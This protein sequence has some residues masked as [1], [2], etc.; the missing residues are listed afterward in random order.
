MQDEGNLKILRDWNG[1]WTALNNLTYVR[2]SRDGRSQKSSFP[3]K[4]L[5]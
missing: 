4:G 3:P 1:E 2:L 5:S